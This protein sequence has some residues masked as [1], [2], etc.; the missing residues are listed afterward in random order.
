MEPQQAARVS[1]Q[2]AD[3]LTQAMSRTADPQD[4]NPLARGLAAVAARMEPADAAAVLVQAMS[5]TTYANSPSQ[6]A[7][8]LSAVLSDPERSDN[9]R[10]TA[11]LTSA[12]G[13]LA[14]TGGPLQSLALLV[15]AAEP[16]PC[17]LSTQQL[18]DV[19]K[20]PTCVGEARRVVLD[21]LGYRC[22]RPFRD[23]WEFVGYARE[24]LPD[25]DLNSPP[26]RPR[27]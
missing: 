16:L 2:A 17:R 15:P 12:A 13:I 10:R 8:G 7:P 25:L 14:G 26:K 18:V 11:A 4:F 21:Y 9:S 20:M 24:H 22:G 1:A 6:L 23:Q 3:A 19:L 27:Q 5:T